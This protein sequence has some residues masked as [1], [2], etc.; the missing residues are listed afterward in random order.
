MRIISKFK[1]FYDFASPYRDSD[2]R[3]YYWERHTRTED[4]DTTKLAKNFTGPRDDYDHHQRFVGLPSFRTT[5]K[6]KRRYGLHEEFIVVANKIVSIWKD[7]DEEKNRVVNPGVVR[8]NE[9]L[10]ST[11]PLFEQVKWKSWQRTGPMKEMSSRPQVWDVNEFNKVVELQKFYRTPI[12]HLSTGGQ[13]LHV[14]V[15]PQLLEYGIQHV[16]DGMQ[17]YQ[18]CEMWFSNQKYDKE[19]P[20]P[21]TDKQ[22]IL[23]HGLDPKT[24]FRHPI[25]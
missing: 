12:L 7:V 13:Q 25:K 15:N 4:W 21:Q 6:T 20:I 23:T 17:T 3:S 19:E 16:L 5:H 14:T 2:A 11:D 18:E 10:Y 24:S 1:D 8:E 22:K 9:P